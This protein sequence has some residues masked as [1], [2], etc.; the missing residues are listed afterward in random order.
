MRARRAAPALASLA[1]LAIAVGGCP[2]DEVYPARDAAVVD[3]A[4]LPPTSTDGG[5]D[6]A[7][8]AEASAPISKPTWVSD[9]G[10]PLTPS[11]DVEFAHRLRHVLDAVA[12]NDVALCHDVQLPRKAYTEDFAHKDPGKLFDHTLDVAFRKA[13]ARLHKRHR[14]RELAFVALD[15]P[16]SM[17][18]LPAHESNGWRE[19]TWQVR[20]AKIRAAVR[21]D[22]APGEHKDV[23]IELGTLVHW[24]GAWYVERL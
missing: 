16:H 2:K 5:S 12:A 3:A 24:R 4:R 20:G 21:G 7:S 9:G 11:F 23:S 6:A 10:M 1:L 18:L 19:P 17:E 22:L 15:A 13:I 14:N 8:D